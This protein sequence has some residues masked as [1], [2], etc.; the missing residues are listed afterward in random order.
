[1][2]FR[3]RL[4]VLLCLLLLNRTLQQC[5]PCTLYNSNFCTASDASIQAVAGSSSIG[6]YTWLCRRFQQSGCGTNGNCAMG[7]SSSS[8]GGELCL[9]SRSTGISALKAEMYRDIATVPNNCGDYG[10]VR[11]YEKKY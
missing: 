3:V 9:E 6:Y 4:A 2:G 5:V 11:R 10:K 1:M 7:S 8:S